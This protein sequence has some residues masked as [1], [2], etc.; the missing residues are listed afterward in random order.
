[1]T[2]SAAFRLV[3]AAKL[4]LLVSAFGI[5][6]NFAGPNTAVRNTG[7]AL[8]YLGVGAAATVATRRDGQLSELRKLSDRYSR[9]KRLYSVLCRLRRQKRQGSTGRTAP[10]QLASTAD[11]AI[12]RLTQVEH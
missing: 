4:P 8:T 12:A 9:E 3:S 7:A 1:M 10:Y 5:L 2:S 6:I 11:A